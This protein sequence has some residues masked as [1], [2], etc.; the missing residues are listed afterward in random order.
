MLI[1]ALL[2]LIGIPARVRLEGAI[3][4]AQVVAR[5]HWRRGPVLSRVHRY[6]LGSWQNLTAGVFIRS[7]SDLAC[8][9]AAPVPF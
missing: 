9:R 1:E 2:L 7:R 5:R 3:A 8:P 4:I 6:P